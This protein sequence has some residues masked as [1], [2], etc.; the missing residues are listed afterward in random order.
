[1]WLRDEKSNQY[2]IVEFY[3]ITVTQKDEKSRAIILK[4]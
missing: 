3:G 1:M 2:N 4:I